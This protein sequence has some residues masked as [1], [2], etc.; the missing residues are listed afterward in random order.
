MMYIYVF[1]HLAFISI[2]KARKDTQFQTWKICGSNIDYQS[3]FDE[4]RTSKIFCS[5][6]QQDTF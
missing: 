4:D 1:I 6:F 2:V 5:Y 3:L